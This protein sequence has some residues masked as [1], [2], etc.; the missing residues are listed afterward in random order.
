MAIYS[1]RDISLNLSGDIDIG[2]NGDIKLADSYES[3]KSQI[4]WFLRTDYGDYQP[5][6]RLGC[7]AGYYIGKEMSRDNLVSIEDTVRAALVKYVV[8]SQD[9][10]VD[11]VP[12]SQEEIGIFVTLRGDYLGED[13]NLLVTTPE[14]LTYTFPYLEGS[15]TPL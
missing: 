8:V 6:D 11:A 13:G 10:N 9:I 14:V 2:S 7:N 4:N 3:V 1:S 5:D 12:L 15:P